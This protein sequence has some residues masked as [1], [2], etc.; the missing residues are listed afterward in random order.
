MAEITLAEP[1]AA[2][3]SQI[4]R[5][6]DWAYNKAVNGG[7]P[8]LS[9]AEE[10][11]NDFAKGSDPRE[12]AN[13]LIRWQNAKC[14]TSGFITGLGGLV[15]LPLSIPANITSVLYMQIR[16]IAAIAHM[17]GHDLKSDRVRTLVL[18]CLAGSAAAD[19]LKDVGIAV[20]KRLTEQTI[21][22]LSSDTI[23]K[24]NQKAGFKLVSKF[25]QTGMINLSKAI[26]IVGGVIG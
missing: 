16:M 11:A 3:R 10:L 4:A 5:V 26:P 6:L 23:A 15:T 21:R 7:I 9:T 18:M 1:K 19:A 14:A 22:Q 24:I 25:G 12:Q 17:G 2:S 8:G 13:K 20:G